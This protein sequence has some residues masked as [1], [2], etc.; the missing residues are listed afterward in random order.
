VSKLSCP[1]LFYENGVFYIYY[2]E[3]ASG[4]NRGKAGLATFTWNNQANSIINLVRNPNNPIINMPED[5]KYLS[6]IGHVDIAKS[7]RNDEYWI[8]GVREV[9]GSSSFELV[10]LTSTDKTAWTNKGTAL[11]PGSSGAWDNYYI[12]RSSPVV[13]ANGKIVLFDNAIKLYYSGWNTDSVPMIGLATIYPYYGIL[14]NP[15][16]G[17]TNNWGGAIQIATFQ[18]QGTT[19]SYSGSISVYFSAVASGSNNKAIV[20]I[21]DENFAKVAESSEVTGLTTGWQTFMLNSAFNLVNGKTYYLISHAPVGNTGR[22]ISGQQNQ[23][24]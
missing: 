24:I 2:V 11:E 16:A 7:P 14:G 19:G 22:L 5:N 4:N 15:Y 9:A 8:Y 13:D 6:G 12:Y 10:T 17:D 18:Y 3:E 23:G 1:T 20:G 21:Y